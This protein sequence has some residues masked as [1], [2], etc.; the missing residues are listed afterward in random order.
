MDYLNRY[1][2][3]KMKARLIH[4]VGKQ[5]LNDLN[6][7]IKI[8]S[9]VI[10]ELICMQTQQIPIS[11]LE[12]LKY[13]VEREGCYSLKSTI[14]IILL[15][16]IQYKNHE[17]LPF[18]L[19]LIKKNAQYVMKEETKSD[20]L[21]KLQENKDT[22][23][24]ELILN[25]FFQIFSPI[26]Y[27]NQYLFNLFPKTTNNVKIIQ[28]PYGGIL[29]KTNFSEIDVN[30]I[31]KKEKNQLIQDYLSFLSSFTIKSM[32]CLYECGF[33]HDFVTFS[34]DLTNWHKESFCFLSDEKVNPSV[35]HFLNYIYELNPSLFE[36]WSKENDVLLNHMALWCEIQ[37][38]EV[39]LKMKHLPL[40]DITSQMI[41]TKNFLFQSS[42]FEQEN[43][44][45]LGI[46]NRKKILSQSIKAVNQASSGNIHMQV[47][48]L[49]TLDF[50][51]EIGQ[52]QGVLRQWFG[53]VLEKLLLPESGI[54]YFEE[55]SNTYSLEDTLKTNFQ[56]LECTITEL[57]SFVY[58][59]F[60]FMVKF[61][62][63]TG[64]RFATHVLESFF[65]HNECDLSR[66][67]KSLKIAKDLDPIYHSNFTK[68][69][70]Q[71]QL[72]NMIDLEERFRIP[73]FYQHHSIFENQKKQ[74]F[75]ESYKDYFTTSYIQRILQG[76]ES[77]LIDVDD[78]IANIDYMDTNETTKNH[79]ISFLRNATNEKLK[80]LYTLTT[81]R[82]VVPCGGFSQLDPKF[83]LQ[84]KNNSQF[85]P[86]A[87]TCIHCF[88][89]PNSILLDDL[90]K[91]IEYFLLTCEHNPFTLI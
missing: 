76:Q 71:D 22:K 90:N 41:L 34:K 3:A 56:I 79:F 35:I 18:A 10:I 43:E 32:E 74:L 54:F 62:Y 9:D 29:M 42:T 52:G 14:D 44:F 49:V 68:L 15:N 85:Y 65:K 86:T 17:I 66:F 30:S 8:N 87:R 45:K 64:Y 11:M 58:V 75:S 7:I 84:M 26:Q 59:F 36:Q 37:N 69:I 50:F 20:L 27:W 31:D 91:K 25:H 19:E 80:K 89:I 12:E 82:N 53:L 46:F 70:L 55:E 73:H 63:Q 60:L 67:E 1:A 13:F 2:N 24:C 33:Q 23:E 78:W 40:W 83:S 51:D 28:E 21:L 81:A 48:F 77:K 6:L 47:N 5:Q 38:Y 72:D 39:K 57:Y 4:I 61:Q 16:W 88:E